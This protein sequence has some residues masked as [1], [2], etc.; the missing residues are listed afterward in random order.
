MKWIKK[1]ESTNAPSNSYSIKQPR[2]ENY[3][4]CQIDGEWSVFYSERGNLNDLVKYKSEVEA[5]EGLY[6]RLLNVY[7]AKNI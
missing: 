3:C 6:N 7:G 4:A 5:Y 1:M 2:D